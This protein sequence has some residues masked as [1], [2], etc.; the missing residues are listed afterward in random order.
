MQLSSCRT[1]RILL[2]AKPSRAPQE[3]CWSHCTPISFILLSPLLIL[4]APIQVEDVTSPSVL[5]SH[6][7]SVSHTHSYA[8]PPPLLCRHTELWQ[9]RCFKGLFSSL[10]TPGWLL[11]CLSATAIELE[12]TEEASAAHYHVVKP[13]TRIAQAEFSSRSW[14]TSVR[15]QKVIV[16]RVRFGNS[17]LLF[18]LFRRNQSFFVKV[19][20]LKFLVPHCDHGLHQLQALVNPQTMALWRTRRGNRPSFKKKDAIWVAWRGSR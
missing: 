2:K 14:Q 10:W 9:C 16:V 20:P 11:L 1:H 19:G 13:Q 15:D 3:R 12:W 5:L 8:P 17:W 4:T 7:S 6:L 18:R